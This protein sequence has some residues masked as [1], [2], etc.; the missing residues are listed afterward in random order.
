LAKGAVFILGV[1]IVNYNKKNLRA[2]EKGDIIVLAGLL[3]YKELNYIY[4]KET[5]Y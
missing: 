2:P 4:E 3:F 1:F 5:E